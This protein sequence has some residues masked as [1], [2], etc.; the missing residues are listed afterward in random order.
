MPDTYS[1]AVRSRTMARV[2]SKDTGPELLLRR[3]LY[4]AGVR[5]WRCHLKTLPGRPDLSFGRARLAIFI[6]G[7]F[8][9]GHP[10]KYWQ[11]RS[12]D[13][14]DAKIRRNQERDKRVDHELTAQGWHVL[15]LW[16]FEV[17]RDLGG[18]VHRV[19]AAL[20]A[21]PTAGGSRRRGAP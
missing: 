21:G 20:P 10:S 17:E 6:D 3:G 2:K 5:G 4:A 11:G 8:W 7:G 16:D 13:Y 1:A 14:W 9:H 12:G 15:R 18:A 19:Q